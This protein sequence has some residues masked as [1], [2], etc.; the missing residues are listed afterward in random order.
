MS[1]FIVYNDVCHESG[2]PLGNLSLCNR[3][4]ER[5]LKPSYFP[6]GKFQGKA[7]CD[8]TWYST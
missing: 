3:L 5:K 1:A 7:Q 6:K 4:H 8:R 2:F